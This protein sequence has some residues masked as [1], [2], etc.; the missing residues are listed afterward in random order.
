MTLF[1][2]TV[3]YAK[4]CGYLL[5]LPTLAF[6]YIEGIMQKIFIRLFSLNAFI[7]AWNSFQLF[8]NKCKY[9]K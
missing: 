5:I 8:G 2:F 9:L 6:T 7:D 1:Y 4:N 3:F